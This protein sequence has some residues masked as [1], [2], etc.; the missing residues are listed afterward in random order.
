MLPQNLIGLWSIF[1]C[2]FWAVNRYK[3]KIASNH[4]QSL[5]AA[6]PVPLLAPWMAFYNPSLIIIYN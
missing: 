3:F 2:F 1:L 4:Q 6:T 5:K